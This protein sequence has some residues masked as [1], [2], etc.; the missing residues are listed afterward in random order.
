MSAPRRLDRRPVR[1]CLYVGMTKKK[2]RRASP[3]PGEERGSEVPSPP[4]PVVGDGH[5]P[6]PEP[7]SRNR[8]GFQ[9]VGEWALAV[10]QCPNRRE[11]PRNAR[12]LCTYARARSVAQ[13]GMVDASPPHDANS[14]PPCHGEGREFESHHPLSLRKAPETGLFLC[15]RENVT[16]A[17]NGTCS[18]MKQPSGL[19]RPGIRPGHSTG[20]VCRRNGQA[21]Q[22]HL[23]RGGRHDQHGRDRNRDPPLHDRGP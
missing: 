5:H 17:G 1:R 4:V 6:T 8:V 23:A 2:A 12:Y 22:R 11:S 20:A 18:S 3:S 7:N 19:P 16:R 14:R 21:S 9:P 13:C 15:G 10:V